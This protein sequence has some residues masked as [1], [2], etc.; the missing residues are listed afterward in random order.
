MCPPLAPADLDQIRKIVAST[1]QPLR[2]ELDA[3]Q[4]V[5]RRHDERL[6]THSGTH[7]EIVANVRRSEDEIKT[8]TNESLLAA[9]RHMGASLE[10]FRAEVRRELLEL[11]KVPEA[12]KGAEAAAVAGAHAAQAAQHATTDLAV[13]QLQTSAAS[14]REARL[15]T[16]G[17]FIALV[18]SAVINHLSKGAP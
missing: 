6:R 1:V 9:Q 13:A 11:A 15:R 14:K 4:N 2:D 10:D 8:A 17:L 12:T 7:R 3:L 5:D 16:F 18:I